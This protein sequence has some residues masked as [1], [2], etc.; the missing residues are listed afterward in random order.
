MSRKLSNIPA[1]TL[2]TDYNSILIVNN[3]ANLKIIFMAQLFDAQNYKID[4]L[5][6]KR[7]NGVFC[8]GDELFS[9]FCY[10]CGINAGV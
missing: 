7:L 10:I 6:P 3:N 8:T 9:I 2:I 4:D 5:Y 1:D